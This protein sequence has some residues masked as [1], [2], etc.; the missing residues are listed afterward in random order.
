MKTRKIYAI[1]N[2]RFLKDGSSIDYSEFYTSR[3]K[4]EAALDKARSVWASDLKYD[5]GDRVH[6][7]PADNEAD[8]RVDFIVRAI[9]THELR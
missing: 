5:Y 7:R 2:T 6:F 9:R 3:K 8:D 4:A 1:E